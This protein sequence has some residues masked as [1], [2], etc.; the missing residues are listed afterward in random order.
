MKIRK[1]DLKTAA[2]AEALPVWA[3]PLDDLGVYVHIPFCV[4]KCPYCDFVTGRLEPPLRRHYLSALE[5]EVRFSPWAGSRISTLFLGG[6]TPSELDA[7]ELGKLF[8]AIRD[9][10]DLS[11]LDEATIECNPETLTEEKLDAFL[12]LGFRRNSHRFLPNY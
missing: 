6:G 11:T 5:R 2:G 3:G 10:F 12:E 1:T 9:S 8:T 7:A 4:Q